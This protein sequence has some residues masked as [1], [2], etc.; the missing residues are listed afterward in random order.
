MVDTRFHPFAGS[1]PLSRILAAVE[2]AADLA[3]DPLIDGVE[4]LHLAGP[5]HIAFAGLPKYREALQGTAAGVVLVNEKLRPYVPEGIRAIVTRDPHLTFVAIVEKLYPQT[6]HDVVGDLLRPYQTLP[7][8]ESDVRIGPGVVLG[9]GVEIGRG[10]VIG[11]NTVIG[12]NVTIG[13]NVTIGANC[14]IECAYLG[15][16]VVL[17][18]GARIGAEGF[19]WLEQGRGNR[20][21]P[22]LGRVILQDRVEIGANSAVDRGALGDTVVGEGTKIDN[23]V[24]VGHNCRIGRN[25][26]VAGVTGLAGSTIIEDSVMIGVGACTTGH[27]TIGAGSILLARAVVTKDV[28]RGSVVGGF[29]AQDVHAWRRETATLRMVS[30]GNKSGHEN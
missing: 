4:E 30:K 11:P 21:I 12:A 25:C 26:L 27:L 2:L 29:P 5:G 28:K 18:A 14:T 23:L 10:T 7:V 22:Q 19:G 1:Q 16:G 3:D 20:K 17:H 8:T 6:V 9:P 13:R 24:Q 15:N